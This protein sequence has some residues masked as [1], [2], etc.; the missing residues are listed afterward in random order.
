M[1]VNNAVYVGVWTNWSK[2]S[3]IG[4]TLTLPVRD[5]SVLIAVL[6][7]FIQL[8][9]GQSW[10]II[11]F[12]AHQLRT[13]RDAKDGLYHQQQAALRN[14]TS[15]F[16]TIWRLS[17]IGWAWRKQGIKSRRKS[18]FL[19]LTGL[20]HLLAFGAAGAFSSHITT[21]GNEVLLAPNPSCGF[22]VDHG[23]VTNETNLADNIAHGVFS[24]NSI[25]S[26]NQNIKDCLTLNWTATTDAPCPFESRMCLGPENSSLRLDTWFIDS[27]D[28][29]GINGQDSQR[30]R[31]RKSATCSP[32]TTQDY[33]VTS[34]VTTSKNVTF[35][36]YA[37][38]YGR[39]NIIS[40][41][42]IGAGP[43]NNATYVTSN[44][45]N[46]EF[47]YDSIVAS[48]YR[49]DTEV[50][51]PTLPNYGFTPIPGLL[52]PGRSITI[53]FAMFN[54]LYSGPSDDL[55]LPAHKPFINVLA[56]TEQHQFCNPSPT[57]NG[58]QRCT[59]LQSI[60][61]YEL[62]GL[63]ESQ[64]G[65]PPS[66]LDNQF[67]RAIA[68]II[69][70]AAYGSSWYFTITNL[71]S[72]LLAND[73]AA[74]KSSLPLAVNQWVLEA[75]NWFSIGVANLQ[76][77]VVDVA[78]GPPGANARFTKG[79]ADSDAGLKQ[80]C[81]NQVI[82]REDFT[83]FS[84]LAIWLIFA[85]GGMVIIISLFL[86]WLRMAYEE[87]GLGRW[88]RGAED[89]P[90]T[91]RGEEFAMAEEWDEWHPSIRGKFVPTRSVSI[92]SSG[93]NTLYGVNSFDSKNRDS[94]SG[95]KQNRSSSKINT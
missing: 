23:T 65:A 9:G 22:W 53:V 59:P 28:D 86:E 26:S 91:E 29:L 83:N 1:S 73:L 71:E 31:Y 38:F 64:P 4:S 66:I 82:Q 89:V 57:F 11:C 69:R 34:N 55:W 95:I 5:G 35:T 37:A 36:A 46:F 41:N 39:N 6:A 58:S 33:I 16:G 88:S 87:V 42:A 94:L 62:N 14:N 19:V 68:K 49:I 75:Q 52:G 81:G 15:D 25:R 27:R 90:I 10:S 80:Y 84:V 85:L 79:Q 24:K 18:L 76:R 2:G 44:F 72:S 8:A 45:Q 48:P 17:K 77:M 74:Q 21:R 40:S 54:G 63:I 93:S 78:T 70:T 7:L 67:Q 51:Y 3:A 47:L 30:V 13:S 50:S 32:I 60:D 12:I 20:F 56:C 43:I 61:Q 92:H